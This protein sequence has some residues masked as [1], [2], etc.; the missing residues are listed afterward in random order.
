MGRRHGRSWGEIDVYEPPRRVRFSWHPDKERAAS[1]EVEVTF[2]AIEGG[3]LV[4]LEHRA[5]ERLGDAGEE[6]RADYDKG[7]DFVLGR[8]VGAA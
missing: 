7:W 8:F 3:T 2:T 6:S 4:R 1:T 5:W